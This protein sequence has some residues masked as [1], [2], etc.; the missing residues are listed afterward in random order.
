M[1]S[2]SLA[3]LTDPAMAARLQAREKRQY[4][5]RRE[6]LLQKLIPTDR[7]FHMTN[8][9]QLKTVPHSIARILADMRR[10]V[11]QIEADTHLSDEGKNSKITERRQQARAEIAKIAAGAKG[12]EQSVRDSI[13]GA[14]AGPNRDDD[15]AYQLRYDRMRDRLGKLLSGPDPDVFR[16]IDRVKGDALALTVLKD[17]APYIAS[18]SNQLG[19]INDALDAAEEPHLSVAQRE[20]KFL[21]SQLD[22][23]GYK[24]DMNVQMA[25]QEVEGGSPATVVGYDSDDLIDVDAA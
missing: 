19:A 20:A 5:Q 22:K 12:V 17:E 2:E 4:Q 16:V 3:A 7:G 11:A 23:G 10:D 21:A 8:I 9:D 6:S 25:L 14:L 24:L 15:T 18:D 1:P 13:A